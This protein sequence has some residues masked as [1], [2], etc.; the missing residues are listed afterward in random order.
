MSLNDTVMRLLRLTYGVKGNLDKMGRLGYNCQGFGD[1]LEFGHT[2]QLVCFCPLI[3]GPELGPIRLQ[4]EY[5]GTAV[6]EVLNHVQRWE[7]EGRT[8]NALP[9]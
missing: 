9:E 4:L 5:G 8:K 7:N 3:R 6:I 1:L 2:P